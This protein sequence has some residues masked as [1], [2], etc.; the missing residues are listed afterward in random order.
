MQI[1]IAGAGIG[2][3][4]AAALL[5]AQGHAV[6]VFDPFDAPRPVGSARWGRG[7]WGRGW[8]GRGW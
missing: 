7:W 4:A 2:G 1:S 8:W 6:T 3:L 5:A